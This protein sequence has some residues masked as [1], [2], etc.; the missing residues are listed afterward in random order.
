[1]SVFFFCFFLLSKVIW[2]KIKGKWWIDLSSVRSSTW[3]KRRAT[4]TWPTPPLTLT[5]F[6][7]TSPPSA[8]YRAT[9]RRR[10]RDRKLAW[11]NRRADG[12]AEVDSPPRLL[13]FKE[14]A[15]SHIC[16]SRLTG[17]TEPSNNYHTNRNTRTKHKH[18]WRHTTF[19]WR[20]GGDWR[21]R[22][23]R[24]GWEKTPSTVRIFTTHLFFSVCAEL[25]NAPHTPSFT[26][27]HSYCSRLCKANTPPPP[28]HFLPL[29]THTPYLAERS[30]SLPPAVSWSSFLSRHT[31]ESCVC[32]LCMCVFVCVCVCACGRC[33]GL[34]GDVVSVVTDFSLFME[35]EPSFE[36]V[37]LL[38]RTHGKETDSGN[39]WLQ[40]PTF[41]IFKQYTNIELMF[42]DTS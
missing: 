13:S 16:R 18:T 10:P 29:H 24:E 31:V 6:H 9:W 1:M 5:S 37:S 33:W 41:S 32:W 27:L 35:L 8:N 28:S 12:S 30:S 40:T 21:R 14:G 4:S 38:Y 17:L 42:Y 3:L 20:W 26:P 15:N 36:T 11:G 19:R 34:R 25:W 2:R 39:T 23:G 22:C 7:W